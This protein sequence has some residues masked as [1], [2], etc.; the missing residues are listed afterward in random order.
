MGKMWNTNGYFTLTFC[1]KKYDE[2]A[3]ARTDKCTYLC[4]TVTA[5]LVSLDLT[6]F[7]NFVQ[8]SKNVCERRIRGD[9]MSFERREKMGSEKFGT[10]CFKPF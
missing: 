1:H 8:S 10:C 5:T 6:V 3:I 7:R 2:P 9:F 4:P